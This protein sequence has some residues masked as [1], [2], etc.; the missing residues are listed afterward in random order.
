M[1]HRRT[2]VFGATLLALQLSMPFSAL[3]ATPVRAQ[4]KADLVLLGGRVYIM[5]AVRSN[6]EAV[7]V[8]AGKI[9]FV[10]NDQDAQ[11]YV[12]AQTKVVEL[13]GRMVLPG[14]YDCHCHLMDGGM[15]IS[16]C[17][18]DN[19]QT[20]QETLETIKKYAEAHKKESWIQGAGW[21]LPLFPDA[22]PRKEDLDSVVADRPVFLLSQDC[23]S[24]WVNS[25]AL[26]L[27]GV[28]AKTPDPPRGRIE[29]DAK[30]GEPS[31]TLRESAVELVHQV[32]PKASDKER[33]DGLER[34]VELANKFGITSVQDADC[35]ADVLNAY[36][37][38]Q[39]RGKLNLKVVACLHTDPSEGIAQLPRLIRMREKFSQGRLRATSAKIFADGVIEAHTAS[40]LEP[41]SD[42]ANEKGIA[43]YTA[44]ELTKLVSMLNLAK[45]QVHIHAIG[46]RAVRD[47]LDAFE[48]DGG[49]KNIDLRNEIAHLEVVAPED[50]PRFRQLGIVANCQPFWAYSDPYIKQCTLPLI[51]EERAKRLYLFGNLYRSG[52]SMCGGSDWPVTTLNPLDEIQV[53]VT[54]QALGDEREAPLLPEQ[55]LELPDAIAA[56]TINGAFVNHEEHETGSIEVG[57]AADLIVVSKDLFTLDPH[58]I[59]NAKVQLTLL[60]GQ[61]VYRDES[62]PPQDVATHVESRR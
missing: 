49:I 45:F 37:E 51:G 31:G 54:R 1:S 62:F 55:K 52:A 9:A 35:N 6:A 60:D 61:E 17:D 56:Y 20:K 3:C 40:M 8:S 14:F 48:T 11:A 4:V 29:R 42:R 34:A 19:A 50:I 21:S 58:E 33:A 30:T 15:I 38:V 57:K 27:A 39:K 23:H 26:Q 13:G 7:A 59:H 44:D 28:T 24:A 32:A 47:A 43:N 10:G 12:G 36:L 46:D 25:K 41:Y 18:L 5:D 16:Q 22:S 2:T 53:A